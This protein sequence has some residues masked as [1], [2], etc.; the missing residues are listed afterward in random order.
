MKKLFFACLAA[1]TF[2]ACGGYDPCGDKDCGDV[3]T[4]C[5]AGDAECIETAVTKSCNARGLCVAAVQTSC[6]G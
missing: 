6:G 1:A 4:Q 2:T 5:E 3:C